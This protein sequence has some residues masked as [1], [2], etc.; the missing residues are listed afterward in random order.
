MMGR[1]ESSEA[2]ILSV[3]RARLGTVEVFVS[4]RTGVLEQG[5]VS[6]Q[7]AATGK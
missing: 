5:P 6:W 3:W 1:E 4:G 7:K 2:V